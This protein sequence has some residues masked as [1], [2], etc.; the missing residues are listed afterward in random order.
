MQAAMIVTWKRPVPGREIKAVEYGADVMEYWGKLAAEGHC[1]SPEMFF[2]E[3]GT[4]MWMVKGDRD[5]ITR[6]HDVPEAQD[7]LVRGELLLDDFSCDF[8]TAG[9]A[10]DAFLARF[11]RIAEAS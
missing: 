6:L 4:G 7:L 11:V 9:D 8:F 2:T 10:S 3:R 5:V 1:T